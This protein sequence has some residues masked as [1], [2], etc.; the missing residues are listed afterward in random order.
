MVYMILSVVKVLNS[1]R[2]LSQDR[3]YQIAIGNI[4]INSGE[5]LADFDPD[6]FQVSIHA[7]GPT[8]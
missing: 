8:S 7:K 4:D 1:T 6:T 2:W 5:R 3:A